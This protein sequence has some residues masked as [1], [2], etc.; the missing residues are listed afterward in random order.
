M[1]RHCGERGIFE[2]SDPGLQHQ[3]CHSLFKVM[4]PML[5]L[6]WRA[7]SAKMSAPCPTSSSV[8]KM[9]TQEMF[10]LSATREPRDSK[11]E[12]DLF[13]GVVDE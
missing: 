2:I 7:A 10:H 11:F 8:G 4:D 1:N 13:E 5:R 6:D 12:T 9:P 3:P